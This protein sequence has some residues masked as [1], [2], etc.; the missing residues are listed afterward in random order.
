MLLTEVAE[1]ISAFPTVSK[2]DRTN[3]SNFKSFNLSQLEEQID[4]IEQDKT[5]SSHQ[6]H[7]LGNHVYS[8]EWRNRNKK[9]NWFTIEEDPYRQN[10]DNNYN[11]RILDNDLIINQCKTKNAIIVKP[12]V[13]DWKI[14]N[15]C[16]TYNKVKDYK[17]IPPQH[18]IEAEKKH[19]DNFDEVW[20]LDIENQV[21][22][23]LKKP[24]NDFLLEIE[25]ERKKLLEDPMLV[26]M[27]HNQPGTYFILWVRLK[28]VTIEE[29]I[30]ES[31]LVESTQ[32]LI[33]N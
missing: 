7:C 14:G 1:R 24:Y 19:R 31:S 11:I 9:E 8:D 6:F 23:D 27:Y 18:I 30:K 33:H 20:V 32:K 17:W 21:L 26:W 25:K 15:C 2:L 28:N 4:N 5:L 12:Y 29:Y 22:H 16:V 3:L 10:H 13:H